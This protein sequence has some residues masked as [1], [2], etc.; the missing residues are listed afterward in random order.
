MQ[1]KPVLQ[2][3]VVDL[4]IASFVATDGTTPVFLTG[5][6]AVVAGAPIIS[7]NRVSLPNTA[8]FG[9]THNS[10]DVMVRAMAISKNGEGLYA[11]GN[12][13]GWFYAYN[14]TGGNTAL[15]YFTVAGS[16]FTDLVN[17]VPGAAANDILTL[18][19]QGSEIALLR[20]NNIIAQ[21]QSLLGQGAKEHGVRNH[22]GLGA[23]LMDD[24]Y[25]TPI[26]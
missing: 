24:L 1:T 3:A 4:A 14:T 21:V 13:T 15:G 12:G 17:Q 25:I 26:Y 18:L 5:Q 11:R 20:N 9:L 6:A 23:V 19:A 2:M 8:K 16:V 10:A 7:T 22:L